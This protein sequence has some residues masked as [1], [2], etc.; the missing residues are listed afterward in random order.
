[1][2]ARPESG[3]LELRKQA[4]GMIIVAKTKKQLLA[5]VKICSWDSRVIFNLFL[6][7][8]GPIFRCVG[9]LAACFKCDDF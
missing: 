6:K 8:F 2:I 9:A 5:H 4:L 1:M 7:A 3:R